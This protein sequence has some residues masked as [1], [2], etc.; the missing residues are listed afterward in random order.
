ME[1]RLA[2]Q[3]DLHPA[4]VLSPPLILGTLSLALGAEVNLQP[5]KNQVFGFPGVCAHLSGSTPCSP[6]PIHTA[7]TLYTDGAEYFLFAGTGHI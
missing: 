7:E 4:A 6:A 3:R 5:D 2:E 1:Q